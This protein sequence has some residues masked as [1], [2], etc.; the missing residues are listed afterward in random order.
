MKSTNVPIFK[1]NWVWFKFHHGAGQIQNTCEKEAYIVK[2][3][4]LKAC[5]QDLTWLAFHL[6]QYTELKN[7]VMEFGN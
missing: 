3:N 4:F 2:M 7:L 6:N 1:Q 5:V